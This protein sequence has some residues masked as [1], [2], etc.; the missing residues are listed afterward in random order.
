MRNMENRDKSCRQGIMPSADAVI[1][2]E[3]YRFT[4]LTSALIRMEYSEKGVFVDLPTQTV[5]NRNF[6]VPG[7]DRKDTEERME[8]ATS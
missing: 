8:I 3:K 4:I 5:A 2:G 7:F 1:K 6:P